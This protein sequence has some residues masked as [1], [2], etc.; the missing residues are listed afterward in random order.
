MSVIL[1]CLMT[2]CLVCILVEIFLRWD[3]PVRLWR[4]AFDEFRAMSPHA[5]RGWT[6]KRNFLF[7]FH[8][9]YLS[10][11]VVINLNT[12][13]AHDRPPPSVSTTADCLRVVFMGGTTAAGWELRSDHTLGARL[14]EG[15]EQKYSSREVELI[16]VSTRLYSTRQL[17]HHYCEEVGR[18]RPD[19]VIYYFNLNDPRRVITGHE[20]GKSTKLSQPIVSLSPDGGLVPRMLPPVTNKNDMIFLDENDQ[21]CKIP[22]QLKETFWGSLT[23]FSHLATSI[24]DLIQGPVRLRKFRDRKEIKD[25]E[26]WRRLPEQV[27]CIEQ[28]PFQWRLVEKILGL[29]A[30]EVALHGGKFF[31]ASTLAYYCTR[32]G[33]LYSCQPNHPWGFSFDRIPERKYL[34]FISKLHNFS[35][36]DTY[37]EARDRGFDGEGFYVHPRY[38][39]FNERG[40][41]FAADGI[42]N[43]LPNDSWLNGNLL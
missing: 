30:K 38:C 34:E 20:S 2:L 27:T 1:T 10:K 28:L 39:Y 26:L 7:E 5:H 31:V 18:Y 13:G 33:G 35:Y 41:K 42:I 32:D 40:A 37:L 16:D 29:W 22:G 14:R 6:Q 36:L 17:Y 9:R 3:N 23:K 4:D 15:L 11:K 8:H 12:L 43:L 25:I 21:I 19:M 24:D